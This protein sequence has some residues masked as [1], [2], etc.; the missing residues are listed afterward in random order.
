[1]KDIR[2]EII[3]RISMPSWRGCGWHGVSQRPVRLC[4]HT[5]SHWVMKQESFMHLEK[6]AKWKVTGRAHR[7]CPSGA[8][9][10]AANG[11]SAW[12]PGIRHSRGDLLRLAMH[13]IYRSHKGGAVKTFQ[14]QTLN[15]NF[16]FSNFFTLQRTV[17]PSR[18]VLRNT[19]TTNNKEKKRTMRS[20]EHG[21]FC[22]TVCA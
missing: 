21:H 12:P 11:L 3:S 14:T 19:A 20:V 10:T 13:E 8:C 16:C 4:L 7:S 18:S 2:N 17:S 6:S 22:I 5:V 9:G 1:M 15:L